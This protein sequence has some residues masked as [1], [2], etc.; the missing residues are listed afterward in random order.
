VI[1]VDDQSGSKDLFPYIQ[2]LTADCLLTRLSPPFGDVAWAGNGPD[3]AVQVGVEYKKID[4]IL[5]C[6]GDGRFRGQAVGMVDTYDRRYLLVEGRI[7]VDRNNGNLQKLRGDRWCDVVKN[8][9]LFTS[10]D[11]EHWLTTVEQQA[12]FWMKQTYDEYESARWLVNKYGWWQ[13]NW[14][15][16]D[17]LKQFHVPPPPAAR[18]RKPGV[19]ERVA[20]EL[21]D[22]GW[23]RS[24]PV[25]DHF[26]SIRAMANAS[27]EEWAAIKVG[28]D[29][30]GHTLTI[31]K[32][33]AR[34]IVAEIT[35]G[36][37][38]EWRK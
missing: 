22:I 12:I 35:S 25:A 20:K 26:G 8:G 13:K 23:D 34:K 3:G 18:F 19:K 9:R 7:R 33:R 30:N 5:A 17:G 6:I 2:Q 38:E 4:D 11:L 14:E 27:A 24:L 37:P 28:E 29:K 32:N 36:D 16:H 1:L 10:R 15:D 31:G 21:V